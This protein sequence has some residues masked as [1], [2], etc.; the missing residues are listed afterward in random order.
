MNL[1]IINAA[2]LTQ[3]KRRRHIPHGFIVVRK[4]KIDK[5]SSGDPKPNDFKSGYKVIN[6]K[7]LIVLPGFVNAHVHLGE[8]IFQGLLKGKYSLEDYLKVTEEITRKTDLV[9]KERK[10]VADY[11]LL[12]LMKAGTTTICG[13]RVAGF[14]NKWRIRNVSG[15]M[16]MNSSKLK[17]L[18]IG[19]ERQYTRE[20]KKNK[21]ISISYPAIFLH[22]LNKIDM[23]A[24]S[25]VKKILKSFPDVRLVLHIAETKNQEREIEE[26][27]GMSSVEFLEKNNLL[28]RRTILIHGNWFSQNDLSLIKK[29]QSSIVQ[30]LSSNI[31]VAD[32]VL[33]LNDVIGIGIKVC[34]A[35]DGVATSGTFSIL[36][37]ARRCF[38][39]YKNSISQQKCLDLITIDAAKVLGLNNTIGSIE[40][41]KKADLFF[42]KNNKR[43]DGDLFQNIGEIYGVMVDGGF[44]IWD[45]ELLENDESGIINKF[46]LLVVKIKEL[47]INNN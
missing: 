41:N 24:M 31:N 32:K 43:D 14:A 2:I 19:L 17:A 36:E 27:L 9:E 42:V 6:A 29:R 37:E 15:Y 11:S 13:G 5:V 20:Y 45:S 7:N 21:K 3:N 33:N 28:N 8:S 35:T 40:K 22:S 26:E 18:S 1:L 25:S 30:C 46:N 34:L 23:A 4:D 38:S 39:Y 16:V 10:I 12:H 47:I 44:K